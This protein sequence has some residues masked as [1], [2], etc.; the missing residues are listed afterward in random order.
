MDIK[1]L[2]KAGLGFRSSLSSSG[3][4]SFKKALTRLTVKNSSFQ[5]LNKGNV[6]TIVDVIKPFEKSIR[7]RGGVSRLQLKK[8]GSNLVK[9]YQTTKGT[10]KEFSK[11][12]VKDAKKIYATY[13]KGYSDGKD[14]VK[15][16]VPFRPYLNQ[17]EN[18]KIGM[19]SISQA[20]TSASSIKNVTD[21]RVGS[22]GVLTNPTRPSNVGSQPIVRRPTGL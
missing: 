12:D 22:I 17:E 9:K 10:E 14:D 3:H 18:P 7:L 21:H 16:V 13:K 4:A 11:E 15:K 19:S 5:N 1:N 20:N 6:D 8:M 2:P